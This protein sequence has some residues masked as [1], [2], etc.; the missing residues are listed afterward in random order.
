MLNLDALGPIVASAR[1]RRGMS[2][3]EASKDSGVPFNTIARVEKGHLPDLAKFKRLVEWAGVDVAQFFEPRERAESTP[4]FVAEKLRSDPNLSPGAADQ[5]AE[6]VDDLYEALARPLKVSA[7]HLRSARVLIPEAANAI[8][9]L[10]E[11]L[12]NEL[13]K[14]ESA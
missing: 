5:I 3:R 9:L 1:K 8:G 11:D 12:E 4:D 6:L 14:R 10:I 7:V 2:L 13:R